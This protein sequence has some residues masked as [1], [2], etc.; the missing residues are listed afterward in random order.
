MF[1]RV[2][3]RIE[4][5]WSPGPAA[6]HFQTAEGLMVFGEEKPP[7]QGMFSYI[8]SGKFTVRTENRIWLSTTSTGCVRL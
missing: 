7:Q 5:G 2:K 3:Q 1:L 8:K 6:G 4:M